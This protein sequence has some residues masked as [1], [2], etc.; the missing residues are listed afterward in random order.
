MKYLICLKTWL[1][2]CYSTH[3]SKHAMSRNLQHYLN[4]LLL[5]PFHAL[6]LWFMQTF[7]DIPFGAYFSPLAW[8]MRAF[9]PGPKSHVWPLTKFIE[10]SRNSDVIVPG[11]ENTLSRWKKR[12]HS[13]GEEENSRHD[14]LKQKPLIPNTSGTLHAEQ[15]TTTEHL[16]GRD[17]KQQMRNRFERGHRESIEKQIYKRWNLHTMIISTNI[18]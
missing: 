14:W 1:K 2:L 4:I 10:F 18:A 7:V 3:N 6:N 16:K 12:S 11:K 9:T 15:Q 13:G 8:V 17:L 5:L